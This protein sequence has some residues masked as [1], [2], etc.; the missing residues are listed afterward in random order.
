MNLAG[1][2]PAGMKQGANTENVLLCLSQ[3]THTSLEKPLEPNGVYLQGT[4]Y[5]IVAFSFVFPC[6]IKGIVFLWRSKL[7][8]CYCHL[9]LFVWKSQIVSPATIKQSEKYFFSFE[10]KEYLNMAW[11]KVKSLWN[12]TIRHS[13]VLYQAKTKEKPSIPIHKPP[14]LCGIS[15]F[16]SILLIL[17]TGPLV[18]TLVWAIYR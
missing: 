1:L 5:R 8:Y 14:V 9:C 15:F 12:L 13:T 16:C 17:I 10:Q 7:W 3:Y 18:S 4:E 2:S 6:K 11:D